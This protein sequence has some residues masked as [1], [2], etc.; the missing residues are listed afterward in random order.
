MH[1]LYL[2][3]QFYTYICVI[4]NVSIKTLFLNAFV[5]KLPLT[6]SIRCSFSVIPALYEMLLLIAVFGLKKKPL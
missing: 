5:L 3:I 1:S 2:H 4:Y 6:L